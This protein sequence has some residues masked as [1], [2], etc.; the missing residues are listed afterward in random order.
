MLLCEGIEMWA[1]LGGY[2]HVKRFMWAGRLYVYSQTCCFEAFIVPK[3]EA[4]VLLADLTRA[5]HAL[6]WPFLCQCYIDF[7][8]IPSLVH[9]I[10]TSSITFLQYTWFGC[11]MHIP[12]VLPLPHCLHW[13]LLASPPAFLSV[14]VGHRSACP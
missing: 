2:V 5:L 8:G 3:S 7:I 4:T 11:S 14:S 12:L 9:F 6:W 13:V 1:L 10:A